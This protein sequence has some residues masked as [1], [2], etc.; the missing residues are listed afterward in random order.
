MSQASL[1]TLSGERLRILDALQGLGE[2]HVHT[3]DA[4][5]DEEV[6]FSPEG[7]HASFLEQA[8]P[9]VIDLAKDSKETAAMFEHVHAVKELQTPLL[10]WAGGAVQVRCKQL[11]F[12]VGCFRRFVFTTMALDAAGEVSSAA[13][14]ATVPPTESTRRAC[15]VAEKVLQM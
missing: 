8:L 9:P 5:L 6:Q 11:G 15:A 12:L 1:K 14:H 2:W 3:E 10:A 4:P 7:W 13:E